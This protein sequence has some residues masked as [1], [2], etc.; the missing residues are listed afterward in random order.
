MPNLIFLFFRQMRAPLLTLICAYMISI[1]VLVLIPGMDNQGNVWY[2][3]FFHAFYF[4]SFMGS[5]IG[6]GEVP[7][8]FTAA[9]RMWVIVTMYICVISWLYAIGSILAILQNPTFQRAL[10]EQRFARKVQ[11]LRKPFY[12]ICGYGDAGSLLVRALQRRETSV[13]VIDNDRQ[14][15]DELLL[16]N[17]HYDV[18]NLCCDAGEV[19]YL[20]AAGIEHAYCIGVMALT[21]SQAINV[22]IAITSKL[23]RPKLQ[24]ICRADDPSTCANLASF[25]TDHIINPFTLFADHLAMALRTPS[26]HLLYRWLISVADVSPPQ[27]ILPPRGYWIVCGYGRFG[28]AVYRYLDFE[29]VAI[30]VIEPS[31]QQAPDDAILGRGTEA[32][33]LR[34]AGIDKA[35]GIVAGTDVD[36]NNLSILMTARELNPDLYLV[37][38]QNRHSNDEIFQA[39]NLDLIMQSSRVIIWRVLPLLTTP[40]L[41]RFLKRVRHHNEEWAQAL[42]QRLQAM[43]GDCTPQTWAL[44]I[45]NETAP[46]IVQA[47]QVG[48]TIKLNT[49]FCDPHDRTQ[50]VPC[51][52]LMLVR[53]DEIIELP[54]PEQRLRYGDELLLSAPSASKHRM[55]WT[56]FNYNRLSYILTG[57][58]RPDGYVWRWWAQRRALSK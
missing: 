38:R 48:Y 47:L 14:R 13:V 52:A 32:V 21:N 45:N 12:L 54:E 39:A 23:L 17:A 29:G 11:S 44:E 40:L 27:P 51:I 26:V 22:K 24:V 10:T 31:E 43:C 56:L 9:Q 3:D 8:E 5:T 46:A 15:L 2:F 1:G 28:K 53:G 36:I 35:V 30:K 41:D 6:F 4:V 16:N 58:T 37:S 18:P 57:E 33:T 49:L 19:K 50:T 55:Q 25:N 42:M 7:Y 34:D 20:Q